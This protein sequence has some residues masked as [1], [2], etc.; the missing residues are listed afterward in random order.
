MSQSH[1][2]TTY[3]TAR[4]LLVREDRTRLSRWRYS[5]W[6]SGQVQ[7]YCEN[8]CSASPAWLHGYGLWHCLQ[9]EHTGKKKRINTLSMQQVNRGMICMYTAPL[10][11]RLTEQRASQFEGCS[12]HPQL[13]LCCPDPRCQHP[14]EQSSQSGE[15]G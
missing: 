6:D 4:H 15:A 7:Q 10:T 11:Y 8:T 3:C 1:G 5:R 13:K 12:R 14:H 2:A 9:T